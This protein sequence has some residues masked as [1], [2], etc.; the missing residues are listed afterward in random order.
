MIHLPLYCL[1]NLTSAIILDHFLGEF[2]VY[3]DKLPKHVYFNVR[4]SHDSETLKID[5]N[6][7]HPNI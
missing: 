7:G 4:F 3:I 1:Q 2:V 5:H 6:V